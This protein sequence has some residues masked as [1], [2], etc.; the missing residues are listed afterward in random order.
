M[1]TLNGIMNTA[2]PE[3]AAK[4]EKLRLEVAELHWKVR[5]TYKVG[6]FITIVTTVLAV[7]AFLVSLYQI[8]NE[9]KE[10]AK[11]SADAIAA[12]AEARSKEYKKPVWERQLAL[13]FELS[14]AVA[15]VATLP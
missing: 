7:A 15:K 4:L 12:E 2:D 5:W 11:R 10:N 13:L 8:S 1:S 3:A 14:D 9:Q 6:Q